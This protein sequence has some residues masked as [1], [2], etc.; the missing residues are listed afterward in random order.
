MIHGMTYNNKHRSALGWTASVSFIGGGLVWAIATS[1]VERFA[2]LEFGPDLQSMAGAA[3]WQ[4]LGTLLLTIGVLSL[5]LY[6]L[7]GSIGYDL[8]YREPAE[9]EPTPEEL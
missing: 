4:G 7:A 5:F 3:S 9:P 1:Q 2:N 8:R 6:L